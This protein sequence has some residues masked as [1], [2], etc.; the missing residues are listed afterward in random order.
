MARRLGET[1]ERAKVTPA[2]MAAEMGVT[3]AHISGMTLHGRG[4]FAAWAKACG[5]LGASMDYIVTGKYPLAD[6]EW[7][8]EVL[9]RGLQTLQPPIT[10]K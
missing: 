10:T 2:K 9:I 4:S 5:V 1:M 3:T 8:R 6:A 7:V